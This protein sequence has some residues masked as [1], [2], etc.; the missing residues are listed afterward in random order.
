MPRCGYSAA[1]HFVFACTK[2]GTVPH[3]NC[4]TGLF[5]GLRYPPQP[6]PLGRGLVSATAAPASPRCFCRRQRAAL[7]PLGHPL[8]KILRQIAHSSLRSSHTI[9]RKISLYVS[10]SVGTCPPAQTFL[11]FFDSLKP[12]RRKARGFALAFAKSTGQQGRLPQNQHNIFS[13]FLRDR[14]TMNLKPFKGGCFFT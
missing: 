6:A 2:G 13:T 12:P 9:C 3:G 11:Y 10:A 1:G 8:D 7:Q 4:L 5:N 14:L